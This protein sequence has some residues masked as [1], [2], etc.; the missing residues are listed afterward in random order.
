VEVEAAGQFVGQQ[1][2]VERLAVRQEFGQKVV[3]GGRP[4]GVMV[5]ARG[6]RLEGPVVL[7]PLMAQLVKPGRAEVK[8]LGGGEGIEPTVVEGGENFLD[9]E[10]RNT[11][12]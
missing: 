2:E 8:P 12:R 4:R 3:G 1:G 11:V 7:Q 9:V 10:R 6:L 5:A